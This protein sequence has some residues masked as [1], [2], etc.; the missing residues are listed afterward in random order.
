MRVRFFE[1]LQM[2]IMGES[3]LKTS[4]ISCFTWLIQEHEFAKSIPADDA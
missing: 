1:D 2:S 4:K 3:G